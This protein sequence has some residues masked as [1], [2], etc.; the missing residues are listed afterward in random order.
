VT[1]D[2]LQCP[3]CGA[4][5]ELKQVKSEEGVGTTFTCEECGYSGKTGNGGSTPVG[6]AGDELSSSD[7]DYEQ[8]RAYFKEVLKGDWNRCPHPDRFRRWSMENPSQDIGWNV[9]E[10]RTFRCGICGKI[11][12][13]RV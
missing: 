9:S 2:Y 7:S 1:E 6:V 5:L 13:E 11:V 4:R 8:Q 12:T 10:R 3:K